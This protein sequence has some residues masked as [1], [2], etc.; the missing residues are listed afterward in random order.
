MVKNMQEPLLSIAIMKGMEIEFELHGD[1]VCPKFKCTCNGKF[2]AR[3]EDKEIVIVG[4]A[5]TKKSS[6]SVTFNPEEFDTESFLLKGVTIGIDFHW[7][8]KE[9]QRFLG[10]LKFL[11]EDNNIVAVNVIPIE[12]Y[13][14]SVISSEMNAASSAELLKA[15]SLISRSWVLAQIEKDL[16]WLF[17]T[18]RRT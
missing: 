8:Q 15:H 2:K 4:E 14:T 5:G 18:V 3:L 13:L 17:T 7:E 1:F 6:E 10:S 12:S 11:I 9:N 16:G